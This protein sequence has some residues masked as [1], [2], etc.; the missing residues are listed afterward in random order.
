MWRGVAGVWWSTHQ[1]AAR[2]VC[3]RNPA[4]GSEFFSALIV[5][6]EKL[7]LRLS[8]PSGSQNRSG[9]AEMTRWLGTRVSCV[10]VA[11]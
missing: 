1:I 2:E 9:V 5:T 8:V 6:R 11:K 10:R 4:L 7:P 3:C